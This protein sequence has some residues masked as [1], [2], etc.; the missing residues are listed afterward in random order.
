MNLAPAI[1]KNAFVRLEPLEERHREPLRAAA[2]DPAI[3]TF[4]LTT[5][6]GERLDSYL[7]AQL[8]AFGTGERLPF[9]VVRVADGAV[10]GATSYFMI[11][12][13]H[14]TVEIGG[15]WY[16]RSVWG[17][18]INPACKVLLLGH[19][20]AAGAGR[21]ELKTDARNAR[22]RAA[23][24]KLGAQLDGVLRRRHLMPD[25]FVRDTALYSILA[26]EWPA[27]R[28]RLEARLAAF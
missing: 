20:F 5:G 6:A 27:A 15:T 7:D 19:A 28:A 10:V 16:D 9:A 8:A 3:W 14:R 17:G 18:P 26:E 12:P 4:V 25:G 13:P 23:I 2:A 22:S 21:V 11:D 24:E 1:L